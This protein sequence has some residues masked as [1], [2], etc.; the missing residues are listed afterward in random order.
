MGNSN[1]QEFKVL[2]LFCGAG[3]FSLGFHLAGY[4]VIG[5]VEFNEAAYLSH[6]ANFPEG[7]DFLG[8]IQ[9]LTDDE[10]IDRYSGVDVIIGGPPC[11]GFSAANRMNYMDEESVKRNKLFFEFIRFVKLLQPQAFVIENVPQILTKNKG[12]ARLAI[13]DILTQEGYQV[14]VEVLDASQYGVPEKRRRAFFVGTRSG[15]YFN[16]NQIPKQ[17]MVTVKEA[18]GDLYSTEGQYTE[19]K[20]E[21]S[22]AYQEFMRKGS[23]GLHNHSPRQH[24]LDVVELMKEVPQGGNWKDIPESKWG[25]RKFSSSTHSS[26][27][28]RADEQQ[29]SRTL[30]SKA[31]VIHPVFNRNI[32]SREAARIQSFPDWYTFTGGNTAQFLQIGNAVPP[33]LSKAIATELRGYLKESSESSGE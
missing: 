19:Y 24:G 20:D 9:T 8:D 5:G 16:F 25:G 4:N 27:Y 31:D 12:F 28:S 22:N 17:P 18:L 32:T 2:D 11:Q 7:N 14:N 6:Q 13:I 29:P 1:K 3:G 21:P 23:L 10:V 33:L 26:V 15:E 30:T